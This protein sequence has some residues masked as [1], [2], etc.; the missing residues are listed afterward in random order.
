MGGYRAGKP[1]TPMQSGYATDSDFEDVNTPST[2]FSDGV[3]KLEK[4]S[5]EKMEELTAERERL[6]EENASLMRHVLQA[7]VEKL[8]KENE[9][10]KQSQWAGNV[11]MPMPMLIPLS[12]EVPSDSQC[13][14]GAGFDPGLQELNGNVSP[15]DDRLHASNDVITEVEDQSTSCKLPRHLWTTVMLRNLPNNY[16]RAMVMKMLDDN[17]FKTK[18]NFLY[19][20]IDFRSGACLG[21]AFVNLVCPSIVQ[22]FWQ[23]FAGFSRWVLPS[24]KICRVSWSHPHQGL[25]SHVERYRSSPVMHPNVQDEHKPIMLQDGVEIPFLAPKKSMRAPRVR[26]ANAKLH[27]S[28]AMLETAQSASQ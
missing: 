7:Q 20:P 21:Y 23:T 9:M 4:G 8:S 2:Q 15:Y 19:L 28:V 16:N 18:Y 24:K 6:K 12:M 11:L 5:S 27:W 1:T 22:P 17:G 13:W 25:E 10:L 3:E 14:T 26:H